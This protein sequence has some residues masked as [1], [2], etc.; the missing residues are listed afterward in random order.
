[1]NTPHNNDVLT[2]IFYKDIIV[3]FRRVIN[4]LID[5]KIIVNREYISFLYGMQNNYLADI[6]ILSN[7][8]NFEIIDYNK[9]KYKSKTK[10]ISSAKSSSDSFR[11]DAGDFLKSSTRKSNLSFNYDDTFKSQ[12]Y[13]SSSKKNTQFKL[14]GFNNLLKSINKKDHYFE[15]T[16]Y[17]TKLEMV[18]NTKNKYELD[19]TYKYSKEVLELVEDFKGGI[20]HYL[21]SKY[22][23]EHKM[24]NAFT[25]LW[26]IYHVFKIF[27]NKHTIRTFHFAEAPGQFIWTTKKFL[28]KRVPN[29]KVHLWKANSL[30]PKNAIVIKQYKSVFDD[31]Y[32]FMKNNPKN[33]LWGEDNTGDI[34]KSDNIMSIKRRLMHWTG[35]NPI[36]CLTGDGGINSG[37]DLKLLQILDY[38]QM[39]I[40][41]A[42]C[43]PG[44]HCVVKTFTPFINNTEQAVT[45]TRL[46]VDIFYVYK[47]LFR[48]LH[49]F[50]PYSS[51]PT[52]GE[53]YIIGKGF[54]GIEPEH[55]KKLLHVLDNFEV[56]QQLF[57]KNAIPDYFKQQYF[58]FVDV[59]VNYNTKA[60]ERQNFL[61]KCLSDN[62][63]EY[64]CKDYLEKSNIDTIKNVRYRKWVEM[65]KFK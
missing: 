59:M 43:S 7:N 35:D 24:S 13:S 56:N 32:G 16:P 37:F 36:D 62:V 41:A 46:Y 11:F 5:S 20:K 4:M 2:E 8:I 40:T 53:F 61:A 10:S 19:G 42:C 27:Q 29:N 47:L 34:T 3:K 14:K 65:F 38:A 15:V 57:A 25:K 33:W 17:Y 48:E 39:C 50:K 21:N 26:E 49:L 63:N 52:S 54:V 18:N 28:E 58:K 1:M 51:D 55:L 31:V 9:I 22:K 44:K 23:M 12:L 64:N 45:T 60:I 30:N 6:F